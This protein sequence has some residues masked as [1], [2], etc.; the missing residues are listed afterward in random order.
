LTVCE[1]ALVACFKDRFVGF[2]RALG[3]GLSPDELLACRFGHGR[4]ESPFLTMA[5]NERVAR[6]NGTVVNLQNGAANTAAPNVNQ[7]LPGTGLRAVD[8]IELQI[9][10]AP[11]HHGSRAGRFFLR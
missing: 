11:Q 10:K 4:R 9:L 5:H 3:Y 6:A 2:A 1:S 8:L 7:D